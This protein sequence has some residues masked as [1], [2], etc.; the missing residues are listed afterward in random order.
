MI[1]GAKEN[2]PKNVSIVRVAQIIERAAIARLLARLGPSHAVGRYDLRAATK[3]TRYI[4]QLFDGEATLDE[5]LRASKLPRLKTLEIIY[6]LVAAGSV[7]LEDMTSTI[8]PEPGSRTSHMRPR[9][10]ASLPDWTADG[11]DSA[12]LTLPDPIETAT[13]AATLRDEI[14]ESARYRGDPARRRETPVATQRVRDALTKSL[15]RL[16]SDLPAARK[17]VTLPFDFG[18]SRMTTK[19]FG[20]LDLDPGSSGSSTAKN[21]LPTK[22]PPPSSLDLDLPIIPAAP[23]VARD[24]VFSAVATSEPRREARR[25]D[26][27]SDGSEPPPAD[28]VFR[29]ESAP[30]DVEDEVVRADPHAVA[31]TKRPDAPVAP[32]PSARK[33]ATSS[34][35][36][37]V[38]APSPFTQ[39]IRSSRRS[40]PAWTTVALA[41]IAVVGLIAAVFF[42][43]RE[44]PATVVR[45]SETPT[46]ART[47]LPTTAAPPTNTPADPATGAPQPPSLVA[48]DLLIDA[49]PRFAVVYVDN[50]LLTGRP[51]HRQ[52]ARDDREH[53][54]RIEAPGYKPLKTKFSAQGDTHLILALEPLPKVVLP[55]P[56][57]TAK[58]TS[59]DDSPYN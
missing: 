26:P 44:P 9:V 12:R 40:G 11:D 19:R 16:D 6:D 42:A 56:I 23:K 34:A 57:V 13:R 55:P 25:H 48:V 4:G 20:D 52:I 36:P 59:P 47:T 15:T 27:R 18:P 22:R 54:V 2:Y 37:V 33:A 17:G 39:P 49:T 24:V 14:A 45:P 41:G 8:G 53:E 38:D 58:P 32:S 50:V 29:R 10:E 30:A 3:E 1:N 46:A 5:A 21:D 43:T 28:A 7:V 35:P 31:P 51:V